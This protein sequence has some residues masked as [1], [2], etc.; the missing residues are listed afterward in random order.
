MASKYHAFA[1]HRGVDAE[2]LYIDFAVIRGFEEGASAEDA[3]V[4][5]ENMLIH[6]SGVQGVDGYVGSGAQV[7]LL[8]SLAEDKNGQLSKLQPRDCLVFV[9]AGVLWASHGG[10]LNAARLPTLRTAQHT[11]GTVFFLQ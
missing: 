8:Q 6:C 1:V 11:P 2:D 4:Q 10:L 7:A 5:P 3:P 9:H